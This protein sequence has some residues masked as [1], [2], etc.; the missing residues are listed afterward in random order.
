MTL[1][2]HLLQRYR[3][4]WEKVIRHPFLEE[5]SKGHL[6]VEKFQYFLKQ[7]YLYLI[8][9]AKVLSI[10]VLKADTL[11]RARWFS[12]LC[13]ETLEVEMELERRYSAQFGISRKELE[14]TSPSS[15]TK[16]YSNF[17]ICRGLLGTYAEYLALLLPC[18][19]GYWEIGRYLKSKTKGLSHRYTSWIEFYSS[20]EFGSLA[21]WLNDELDQ[22]LQRISEKEREKAQEVFKESLLFEW[23]FF[24]DAWLH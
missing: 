14:K 24:E 21:R 20:E 4:I 17:L 1:S 15:V 18:Q 2:Q 16:A 3:E 11:E 12:K 13:F 23:R 7:D 6:P 22:E 5:L 8:E 10:G 9:F 19:W